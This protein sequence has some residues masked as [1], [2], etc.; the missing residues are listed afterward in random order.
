MRVGNAFPCHSLQTKPREGRRHSSTRRDRT[1]R[2]YGTRNEKEGKDWAQ[3]KKQDLRRLSKPRSS[4]NFPN[5]S[6]SVLYFL[7]KQNHVLTEDKACLWCSI[8][9]ILQDLLPSSELAHVYL[10]SA[11]TRKTDTVSKRRVITDWLQ[12]RQLTWDPL[13]SDISS[14]CCPCL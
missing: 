10:Q 11:V 14:A 2:K 13:C 4:A 12:T 9:I 3:I 1:E 6:W 5:P 8:I 7:V